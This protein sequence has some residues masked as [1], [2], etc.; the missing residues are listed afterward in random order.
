[1]KIL[2]RELLKQLIEETEEIMKSSNSTIDN[3]KAA[4]NLNCAARGFDI[5][6]LKEEI[7]KM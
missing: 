3:I 2:T 1:M 4:L 7:S 6:L 5:L